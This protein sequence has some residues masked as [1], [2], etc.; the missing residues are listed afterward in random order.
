MSMERIKV[1]FQS[2]VSQFVSERDLA[3][4]KINR[5][6]TDGGENVEEI[7]IEQTRNLTLAKLNIANTQE[8]LDMINN[9]Y[10]QAIKDSVPPSGKDEFKDEKKE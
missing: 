9:Q 7:I 2:V 1:V 8:Q 4:S 10:N 5:A 6:L 3:I